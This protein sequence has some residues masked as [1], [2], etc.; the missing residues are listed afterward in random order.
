VVL[1]IGGTTLDFIINKKPEAIA[2]KEE[3]KEDELFINIGGGGSNAS[4]ILSFLGTE[5]YFLTKLGN[6][7]FSRPIEDFFKKHPKIKLVKTKK[8]GKTALSFIFDFGDRVIYTFRGSNNNLTKNDLLED[9]PNYEWLYI[10]SVKGKTTNFVRDLFYESKEKGKKVFVNPSLYSVKALKEEILN[11]DLVVL[12]KEEAFELTGTSDLK[13]ALDTLNKKEKI[14]K[15]G[16]ITDGKNG[17]YFKKLGNYYHLQ[18]S[19]VVNYLKIKVRDTTGAGDC[20][21]ASFF[22]FFVKKM[23]PL[24]DSL[25]LASLNSMFLIQKI[26]TKYSLTEK[27]LL[28]LLRK[29]KNLFEIKKL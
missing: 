15:I 29:T 16:I 2:K 10:T 6:D 7:L 26:G 8:E 28:N 21:S 13:E 14:E 1:V 18:I 17:V 19:K 24:V 11:S 22:H 9:L 25:M 5:V 4:Y 27:E 23:F 3:I 12:N 20:F